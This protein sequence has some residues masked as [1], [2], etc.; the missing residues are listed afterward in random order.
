MSKKALCAIIIFFGG[1]LTQ[2]ILS[3]IANHTQKLLEEKP[4]MCP[5]CGNYLDDE[6]DF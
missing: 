1:F 6:E 4:D 3:K 5:Y 2:I